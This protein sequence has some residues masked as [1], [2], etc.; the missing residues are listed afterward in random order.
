MIIIRH[1]Q[2]LVVISDRRTTAYVQPATLHLGTPVNSLAHSPDSMSVMAPPAVYSLATIHQWQLYHLVALV[3]AVPASRLR[4]H[5]HPV[6]R[7]ASLPPS[8]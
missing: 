5:L 2:V 7:E 6:V 3:A 8:V 1:A 4:Y